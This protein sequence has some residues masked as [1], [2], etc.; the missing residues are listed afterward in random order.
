[1]KELGHSMNAV[2]PGGCVMLTQ[3]QIIDRA[4]ERMF[5]NIGV[6]GAEPFESQQRIWPH[7]FYMP[8]DQI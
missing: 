7:M 6:T 5:E 4:H 3:Q 1:M 2:N 8:P